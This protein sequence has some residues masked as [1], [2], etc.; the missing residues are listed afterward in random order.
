MMA[1]PKSLVLTDKFSLLTMIKGSRNNVD[2]GFCGSD[3]TEWIYEQISEQVEA[4]GFK[5]VVGMK[6]RAAQ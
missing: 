5:Q 3:F 2:L 1:G 6:T 4:T